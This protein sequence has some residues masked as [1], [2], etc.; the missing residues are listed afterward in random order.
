M[1][2]PGGAALPDGAR[3]EAPR[4]AGAV[5]GA[6]SARRP[7]RP[8]P[9]ASP[10]RP[11]LAQRRLEPATGGGLAAL[12]LVIRR[13]RRLAIGNGDS[14]GGATTVV[15]GHSPGVV[16]EVVRDGGRHLHLTNLHQLPPDKVLQAWVEK[17]GRVVSAKT[18]FVPNQDGTASATIEDMK[19]V[20]TV[21]VTARRQIQ[22]TSAPIVA[23]IPVGRSPAERRAVGRACEDR[24][25]RR[26]RTAQRP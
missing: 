26:D 4:V 20:K 8:R 1:A 5:D 25:R 15:S 3:V 17:E 2:A 19:G 12:V 9:P 21:M 22:P 23:V 18:L 7:R 24:G 10:S 6:R 14:G 16:A 13:G 11:S